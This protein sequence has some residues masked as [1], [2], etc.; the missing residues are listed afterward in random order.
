MFVDETL[1]SEKIVP[2]ACAARA[3]RALAF[4]M[5]QALQRGRRA[6]V[7]PVDPLTEQRRRHVDRWTRRR[8]CAAGTHAVERGRVA[9]QASTRRRRR[10][11]C[12]GTSAPA[13][14]SSR[15]C[16]APQCC[17]SARHAWTRNDLSWQ[18]R[19]NLAAQYTG[20]PSSAGCALRRRRGAWRHP[21]RPSR[22]RSAAPC[23]RRWAGC[24]RRRPRR[25]AATG[26]GATLAASRGSQS[27]SNVA[28]TA[29]VGRTSIP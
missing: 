26:P 14:C 3:V 4:V 2:L 1:D 29:P 7:R 8:A 6:E 27:G 21:R 20:G 15:A 10:R 9:A 25:A 11:R 18:R 24:P 23:R 5:E 22:A 13:C 19:F 16:A 17:S 28:V 12:S